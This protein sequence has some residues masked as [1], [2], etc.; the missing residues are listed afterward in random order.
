METLWNRMMCRI[1]E[2]HKCVLTEQAKWDIPVNPTQEE[3][4]ILVLKKL[5]FS[6]IHFALHLY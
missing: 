2:D 6:K 5:K 4:Q 1:T 3:L